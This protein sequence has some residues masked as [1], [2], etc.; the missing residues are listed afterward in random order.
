M[1]FHYQMMLDI[2]EFEKPF[3]GCAKFETN[4]DSF[5]VFAEYKRG[6]TVFFLDTMGKMVKA[7]TKTNIEGHVE[8]KVPTYEQVK[9]AT[10][11]DV[12]YASL[13]NFEVRTI[14][15]NQYCCEH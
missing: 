2:P 3:E 4:A 13:M 7:G 6:S 11:L 5:L 15:E 10:D 8:F 1:F 14:F 12:D 9:L